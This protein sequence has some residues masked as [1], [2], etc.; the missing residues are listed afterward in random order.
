MSFSNFGVLS[1]FDHEV[2]TWKTYKCRLMQLF[3]ANE[4]SDGKDPSGERRRA[5]LLSALT[6]GTYKLAADLA[7]PKELHDVPFEDIL[8]LL[9]AHFTPKQVGFSERH[10]FYA[11]TQH[12]TETPSQWAA[13]LRGLTSHCGFTNVEEVL[14]DRFIM[15]M[16]AGPEKEKMYVQDLAALTLTKAVELA[17]GL[18]SARAAAGAAG[19]P[20][21]PPAPAD[22]LYRIARPRAASA[23]PRRGDSEKVKCSVCGYNNHKAD[24]C[25]FA[26][27]SCR[28]CNNKGHLARMCKKVNFVASTT[29]E[30]NE[31]DDDGELFN[32]RSVKGE[33]LVE[34][35]YVNGKRLQFEI[36]SGSAVTVVSERTF[37]LHFDNLPLSKTNKK[38]ISYTG[39]V[40]GCVGCARM[41][42]QW[43]DRTHNIDVYVVRGGGPPLLG[44]DFIA[45]FELQLSPVHYCDQD[46][47][48]VRSF[49]LRYPELFSGKL[50][51]FNLYE[52]NITLKEGSKPVFCKARPVAFALRDKVGNELARLVELGVLRPV[53]H[54][55]YASP[56]VPVLKRDGSVRICA[57]YSITINKQLNIDQYPLPT[58]N[59]LF[60]KLY[61]GNQFTKL[62]LSMA[63]NQFCLSEESQRLTCINTH[64]GLFAYTRLVF[65]LASAPSIFQRAME[66]LLAGI[67]GVL[68]L[69]DDVLVTGRDRSEHLDRLNQVLQRLQSAG[70]TLQREKCDFFK[71]EI[72]YLGYVINKEGLKKSADK[73]KAI[74]DAPTPKNVNQLQSF[75]GLVNYYRCF[76]PGASC[77]LSPLYE[78]LKKSNKWCWSHSEDEAFNKIKKILAS[79]QVLTH[80]NPHAK[81]ILTVDAS[82]NGLGAILSQISEDGIEKPISF[83]SRTLNNAERRYSQIQKEATAII[84]GVRRFHQYLYG[85]S[86]PFV[87]RTDHKPLLSI[88]GPHKGIP[89]VSANRLQ[90]YA[91]FL[92]G[93]NYSI[94]YI[95]SADNTADYL[96]R[97][98]LP[99]VIAHDAGGTGAG[100]QHEEADLY[101]R[102][103]YV[104]FVVQGTLPITIDELRNATKED[105]V[106]VQVAKYVLNGWPNTVSDI[107]L[108]PYKLCQQELSYENGCLMRGHKIVIPKSLREGVLTE[109]HKSHLGIVKTKAE[110]RAR[111][112]FPGIDSALEQMIGSC[113]V[114]AQLRASPA[115]APLS[116]WPYPAHPFYRVHLDFLGPIHGR[117]YLVIVDAY[118]KWLEI[119]EMSTCTTPSVIDKLYDFM[120]RFG[121]PQTLVTDNGT[122]FCAQEFEKFC[123]LNGI[124]HMTS[125][126]YH[127]AS[128]GQAESY[129]KIVKRGIKSSLQSS[130][131]LRESRLNLLKYIF[132]YRNS[133]HSTTGTTPAQLVFGRK[134]RSR[135][136]LLCPR[137]PPPPESPSSAALADRVVCKQS[138]QTE[139]H[140]GK[141]R[142]FTLGQY[143]W[144]KKFLNNNKFT[145]VKGI[146]VKS[147]GQRLF[148]IK[149]CSTANLVKRHT[150]QMLNCKASYFDST[151][152]ILSDNDICTHDANGFTDNI[153]TSLPQPQAASP[154]IFDSVYDGRGEKEGNENV[155][156]SISPP[157]PSDDTALP[158]G[159]F[160]TMTR[161][162]RRPPESDD[163]DFYDVPEVEEA[164]AEERSK[165]VRAPID[166][167]RFF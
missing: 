91:L 156:A 99:N 1:C 155:T 56:I 57:D 134:L 130:S 5:I 51:R 29:S 33:P 107:E 105:R 95:K 158:S 75:L 69:L 141:D 143:V 76:V 10:R 85:R 146:I 39:E 37:K 153:V 31:G 161:G 133:V 83:A 92:S 53:D 41:S 149:D 151:D 72:S 11:A 32:I 48:T 73:V 93:Y 117:M 100:T 43:R 113:D 124:T 87:L 17:E 109:L 68:V 6:E 47:D 16:L 38:L 98:S 60:S 148:L 119:Y 112:W 74:L 15:G 44:R 26:N 79:D 138:L 28:K 7:L 59:E 165:R 162:V 45:Q 58:V 23:G 102:A 62:D 125:P 159:S 21:A 20:P 71:N 96:S 40:L 66:N 118:T 147:L 144:Y 8:K 86:I 137:A 139:V 18:R 49:H 116:P 115:R 3:I 131:N 135:L 46:N 54:A 154:E 78:L 104:C 140:G 81:I 80:F 114:C 128:N 88:F 65:G 22:Q 70:L 122:S 27:Y 84:F 110:A 14:R 82:P 101:D 167:R 19:A 129:V 90:R 89:E 64:R 136:D 24:A 67:S 145:W 150:N 166:Y 77:I 55:E 97:A 132:D 164:R 94:E 50:G 2:H 127:P 120:S 123:E 103:A 52:V 12:A 36:D 160:V 152:H 30:V 25:R 106:L 121:L 142:I 111:F 108:K 61:G 63:Y 35:V 126:P 4:I 163:D 34:S 157:P 42:L 13:R 9:D